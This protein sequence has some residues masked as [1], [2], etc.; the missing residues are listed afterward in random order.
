MSDKTNQSEAVE[1]KKGKKQ[2]NK[3][4]ETPIFAVN[5]LG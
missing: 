5:L 4:K 1:E 3:T 2:K